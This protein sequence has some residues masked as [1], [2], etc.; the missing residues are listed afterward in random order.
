M[1]DAP[2][3]PD[4]VGWTAVLVATHRAAESLSPNPAFRDPLAEAL[5][6]HLGLSEPG[7]PPDFERMP[8]DMAGMARMIGDVIVLRTLHYDQMIIDS[9]VEQIVLLGA[10]LDGRAYRQTWPGRRI[11]ELDRPAGLALKEQAAA[12]AGVPVLTERTAIPV[13]LADDWPSALLAAGFDPSRPTAWIAEGLAVYLD[14]PELEALLTRA[15]EMS[16]PGSRLGIELAS[17]SPDARSELAAS[18]D[19][20]RRFEGLIRSG[21]PVP[22]HDWL[23]DHGWTPDE[24]TAVELGWRYDRPVTSWLDPDR[25]GSALWY[26]SCAPVDL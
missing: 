9:G 21:H 19:G 6:V 8:G 14:R 7:T 22:P 13:D 11:F 10:G 26:F 15:R 23:L 1:T 2:T 24:L 5:M 16:A 20:T 4:G 18:D 17:V 25:G 12:K 3:L